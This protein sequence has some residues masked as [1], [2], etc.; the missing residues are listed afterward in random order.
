MSKINQFLNK[1]Y[2]MASKSINE[3]M[4]SERGDTNFISMLLI[5]GIVVVLAGVFLTFGEEILASV[6]NKVKDFISGL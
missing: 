6:T 5:I 1:Q 2:I 4:D 3:F